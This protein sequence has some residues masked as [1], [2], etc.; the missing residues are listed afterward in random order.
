VQVLRAWSAVDVGKAVN[1]LAVEGQIEGAF[2]QGVGFALSEEMIWDGARLANPTLMD[3]KIPTSLDVPY[4][5][6]S[7][8]V[9]AVDP[10][11]PYGAKGCGEIGINGVAAAIANALAAA[12]GVRFKRLP[13]TP[14]RILKA[15]P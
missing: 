2:V 14:E 10:D 4:E 11:G 9:E 8:I 6:C 15:L 12:T 3:Y 5:I 1:P 7:I 13:M